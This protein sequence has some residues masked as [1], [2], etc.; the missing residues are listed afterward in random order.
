M[1]IAQIS[2]PH[3]SIQPGLDEPGG[4]AAL[5]QAVSHLNRL[6]APPEYA[7]VRELL[8]GLNMPVY[9]IPGNHHDRA[10]MLEFE[11]QGV[12]AL[13]GFVQ[14][15]VEG[16]PVRLM[17]LDTNV[18]GQ[19]L[20]HLGTE[21]LAWLEARLSERPQQPTV[22]FMHHPPFDQPERTGVVTYTSLIGD[23]PAPQLLHDGQR[24]L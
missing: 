10:Q 12:Q 14:Y 22:V 13:E 24:W 7:W 11:T 15:A 23:Y 19:G 16:W 17:G 8:G 1:I 18:P 6:P 9:V 3:I 5:G 21:R 2:D 4:T 20:G